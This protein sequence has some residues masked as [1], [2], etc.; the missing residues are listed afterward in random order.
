[1]KPNVMLN[2]KHKNDMI[3]TSIVGNSV[4]LARLTCKLSEVVESRFHVEDREGP[5]DDQA[6]CLE[7]EADLAMQ[8]VND[9]VR[10]LGL[11][12]IECDTDEVRV[13][14]ANA[15]TLFERGVQWLRRTASGLR[16]R[17]SRWWNRKVLQPEG[18][19]NGQRARKCQEIDPE[20]F[21]MAQGPMPTNEEMQKATISMLRASMRNNEAVW[22][23][24]YGI[25][26]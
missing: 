25:G 9:Q 21:A 24:T 18:P 8:A 2:P 15:T 6:Q 5:Q 11:S 1:M 10:K 17:V 20:L 22:S 23:V 12:H 3:N 26:V 7:A 16:S 13:P 19:M 14:R 4:G